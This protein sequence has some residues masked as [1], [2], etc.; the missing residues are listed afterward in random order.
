M[1]GPVTNE[2]WWSRMPVLM[3]LRDY[4]EARE[5]MGDPDDRIIPFIESYFRYQL[6]HLPSRPLESWARARGGDNIDSVLWLYNRLYDPAAPKDTAWLLELAELLRMQTQDWRRIMNHTTVREHVNADKSFCSFTLNVGERSGEYTL[7]AEGFKGNTGRINGLESGKEY[8]I[9]VSAHINGREVFGQE[10]K[11]TTLS[12]NEDARECVGIEA[13]LIKFYA[14]VSLKY[15][16]VDG[17]DYYEV[18]Y[19]TSEGEY[20]RRVSDFIFN[21]YKGSHCFER[22]V[23]SLS[24]DPSES[25]YHLCLKAFKGDIC[26]ASSGDIAVG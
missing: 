23:L 17:A 16:R 19:G 2:D 22:D 3:A 5:R 25:G 11:V 6:K 26:I 24:L 10:L 21:P 8:Y 13:Q 1:F 18:W 12:H 7:F 4:L 9:A 14:G 15:P 20:P